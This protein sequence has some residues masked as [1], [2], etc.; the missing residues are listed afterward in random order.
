MHTAVTAATMAA[1][2]S[3]WASREHAE[4]RSHPVRA[5]DEAV[6]GRAAGGETPSRST[7]AVRRRRETADAESGPGHDATGGTASEREA[8]TSYPAAHVLFASRDA[9]RAGA[10]DSGARRPTRISGRRSATC[11]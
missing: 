7:R 4:R 3:R 8:G 10:G 11:T 5:A 9:W 1:R 6:G 2:R